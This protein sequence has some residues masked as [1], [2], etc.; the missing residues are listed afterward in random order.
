M[1]NIQHIYT[2][3]DIDRIFKK[4]AAKVECSYITG[5]DV[6]HDEVVVSLSNMDRKEDAKCELEKFLGNHY[7][8]KNDIIRFDL[9]EKTIKI[10]WDVEEDEKN[11]SSVVPLFSDVIYRE[12]S[13]EKE[14]ID[15]NELKDCSVIAFHSYKGG[16]GR[17]LSLLAFAK[18]W[19]ASKPSQKLL[20]VDSDIEAPGLTWLLEENGDRESQLSYFDLLELIKSSEL[21]SKEIIKTI[22]DH[23]QLQ[24]M[25]IDNGEMYSEHYFVPTYR[26]EEQ[27]LDIYASPDS[28]VKGYNKK[29]ILAEKLSELGKALG[30]SAVL[31]DLRAGIS[32]FSAPLLFDPRVRK[33]IV[34]STSYQSI[35]GTQLI[36]KEI[37]KGL[38][39]TED[40]IIPNILLTM[41]SSEVDVA[42]LKGELLQVYEEQEQRYTDNALLELP[43]ASELVHL[44][45][46]NQILDKLDGRD[47]YNNIFKL[48]N[49]FYSGDSYVQESNSVEHRNEVIYA[50]HELAENQINAELNTD[51]NVLMTKPIS[52]LT[53]KFISSVPQ[54]VVIGAKGAGKTFL[55]RELLRV[56]KWEMFCAKN[57]MPMSNA[58]TY[59]IPLI[60]PKNFG[61]LNDVI[62]DAVNSFAEETG[63][64]SNDNNYWH[65]NGEN[66][67]LNIK[68]CN[69]LVQWKELWKACLLRAFDSDM[70]N[71]L[72]NVEKVLKKKD[73]KVLFLVDGLEEIFENTSDDENEKIAIKALVQDFMNEIKLQY[74]HVG[75]LIFL[76]KDLSNNSIETNKEQFEGQNKNYALNWT[77]DEAL[78]LALWLVNQAVPGFYEG[79]NG[80][81]EDASKDAIKESLDKLWGLKLGPKKSNEAYSSRW[82]LAAL[83]DF[84]SQL[85]ARDIVRF[86]ANATSEV[87]NETYSDRIIMPKEVK[88]AVQV[89]SDAK[90]DEIKQ[91][92]K[93]IKTV[94]EKLE[95]A[96]EAKK[97]LPF[98]S[99]DFDLTSKEEAMMIQEGLLKIDNGKY[100]IP[101]IIRHSLKFRYERGARPK[102]LSL[103][104]K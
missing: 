17:T 99:G 66:L 102:V 63:L 58:K 83:S 92:M 51:F 65:K 10:L 59:I 67:I 48:V 80:R 86:L 69:N 64:A 77:H 30:A 1:E 16:V 62:H 18:A 23:M 82:I 14:I 78:R 76:R 21:D 61:E 33:Y 97:V 56:K 49:E 70:E 103:L 4:S 71:S 85:Q 95:K 45:S 44:E 74:S 47:F 6:Y 100:Y 41:T 72:D 43:F 31:I 29:Y 40:S 84:N 32:E 55:Y 36:L 3:K 8:R 88:K 57:G 94:I 98:S 46:L 5:V 104:L 90:I 89:C 50:I 75:M 73:I 25:K 9:F 19:S 53:K 15:N 91:E 12:N 7:D 79:G 101:E 20:I 2:W 39:V 60:S 22:V 35:K 38:P 11:I 93:N 27:L 52:N 68:K 34:S 42:K 87:G 24:T 81:V 26:Y 96:P 13:Y 37:C 54:A 28:I